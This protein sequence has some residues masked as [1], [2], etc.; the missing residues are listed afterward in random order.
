MAWQLERKK[1]SKESLVREMQV[2]GC[3][4]Y[5]FALRKKI[6]LGY[7]LLACSVKY[8]AWIVIFVMKMAIAQIYVYVL[9]SY[10]LPG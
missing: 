4:I 1:V 7:K 5:N 10:F 6:I 2:P 8:K 3:E 9:V